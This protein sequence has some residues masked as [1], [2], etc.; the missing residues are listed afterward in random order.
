M[1]TEDIKPDISMS[2]EPTAPESP[3]PRPQASV[4]IEV[5]NVG[6]DYTMDEVAANEN[7][8]SQQP[9]EQPSEYVS[10]LE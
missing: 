7:D 6:D 1:S 4:V 5:D 9:P 2:A 3:A 10:F 8:S